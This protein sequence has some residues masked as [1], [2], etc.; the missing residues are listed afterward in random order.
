MTSDDTGT[1]SL[2]CLRDLTITQAGEGLRTGKFTSVDLVRAYLKRIEET[3]HLTIVMHMDGDALEVAQ[4]LDKERA[5][6]GSRSP[7]HGI[8]ILV[9]DEF[10]PFGWQKFAPKASSLPLE[11]RKKRDPMEFNR[12]REA[13]MIILGRTNLDDDAGYRIEYPEFSL[14]DYINYSRFPIPSGPGTLPGSAKASAVATAIGL[15]VASLGTAESGVIANAADFNLVG[16]KPTT[17]SMMKSGYFRF[18]P[19]GT[20][21]IGILA[22]TVKDTVDIL[23]GIYGQYED[24]EW[25]RG[26]PS[27]QAPEWAEI[28]E[29]LD[30]SEFT[31]GIP[32]DSFDSDPYPQV[33]DSFEAALKTLASTGATIEENAN[34][35]GGKELKR[36]K[37]QINSLVQLSEFKEDAFRCL[38]RWGND[39]NNPEN[40][41]RVYN[42][43]R[44]CPNEEPT[45]RELNKM[46]WTRTTRIAANNE[47]YTKILE[48]ALIISKHQG[49]RATMKKH[50]LD[51]FVIPSSDEGIT[52]E[53]A[54]QENGPVMS[55]PLGYFPDGFQGRYTDEITPERP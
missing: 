27:D 8:P 25:R 45:E 54:A 19:Q 46:L 32:R 52:L 36:L 24:N 3:K 30:L 21:T 44:R 5:E 7:L 17:R 38:T 26:I 42:L 13:G 35:H 34:F 40:A 9:K 39:S 18:S 14:R 20:P 51:M 43:A 31:I 33:M 6:K 49:I 15:S 2:P 28:Y 4:M 10:L 1:A 23:A 41:Q 50:R 53:L 12:L 22:K 11:L 48:K 16:F 37:A 29:S 55:V 47:E